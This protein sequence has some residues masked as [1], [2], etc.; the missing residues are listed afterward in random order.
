MI[1]FLIALTILGLISI[2]AMQDG[3]IAMW[4][5]ECARYQVQA[6]ENAEDA[7]KYRLHLADCARGGKVRAAAER[8]PIRATMRQ[9]RREMGEGR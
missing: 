4:K 7:I 2:V 3:E 6:G 1:A 5:R 8:E 9:M